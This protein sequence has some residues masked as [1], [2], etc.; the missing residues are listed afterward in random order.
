MI[1]VDNYDTEIIICCGNCG[2]SLDKLEEEL[3]TETQIT[4]KQ[5]C[6]NCGVESSMIL[7]RGKNYE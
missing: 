3:I 2:Q 6:E 5:K 7:P 4:F 1:D